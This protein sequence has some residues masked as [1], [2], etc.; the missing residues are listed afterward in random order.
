MSACPT[1][2]TPP[3]ARRSSRSASARPGRREP[4]RDERRCER[5]PARGARAAGS[6]PM[7]DERLTVPDERGGEDD[8]GPHAAAAAARRVRRPEPRARAARRLP[9]RRRGARRAARPRAAARTAGA[10]QDDARAH[11]RRRDGRCADERLRAGDRPQGRPRGDP[12]RPRRGRR[13]VRRRDPPAQPRRR[14]A[15]LLGDGGSLASTSWSGRAPAPARCGSAAAVHARR[16]DDASGA[17]SP[18]PCATASV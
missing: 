9:R 8:A 16:G 6:S 13:P 4:G 10:R 2:S 17:C 18:S 1:A 12:H 15:A 3:R 11:H 5:P 7:S 14:G